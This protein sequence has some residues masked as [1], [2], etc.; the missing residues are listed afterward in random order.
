M[1]RMIFVIALIAAFFVVLVC[2]IVASVINLSGSF[3]QE[4]ILREWERLME[5][6]KVLDDK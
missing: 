6:D 1:E 3:T 5:E 4:E 2:I